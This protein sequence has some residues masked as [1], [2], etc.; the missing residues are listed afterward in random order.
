MAKKFSINGIKDKIKSNRILTSEEDAIASFWAPT[1]QEKSHE[2]LKDI[3]L[4]KKEHNILNL[5]VSLIVPDPNQPRKHFDKLSLEDLANSIRER[6]V[7]SPIIVRPIPDG[8]YMMVAGERR[9]RCSVS[10][11]LKT[12]PSIIKDLSDADAFMLSLTENIQR[13]NLHYLDESEAFKKMINNGYVRD[14][15]ELAHMLGKSKAYISEKFK[16]LSLP[17]EIKELMYSNDAITFSHAVLLAQVSNKN[18][19]YEIAQKIIKGEMSVRKLELLISSGSAE[20]GNIAR[21]KSSFQP[22]QI[23]QVSNGFNLIVKYRN[24]RPEDII[25]IIDIFEQKINEL[26]LYI[27]SKE[28]A[29]G[30]HV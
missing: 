13:E 22:I 23:T 18:F 11:G 2:E 7:E 29:S 17:D 30:S 27:S 12:I 20:K 24:D 19:S 9:W 3:S 16:I 26:K 10:L 14:Q 8:K 15:K 6:G 5:D 28:P 4:S 1:K 25:K 21:H